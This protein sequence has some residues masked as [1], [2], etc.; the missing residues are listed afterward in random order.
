MATLKF[1]QDHEWLSI[2]GDEAV[3]GITEYAQAQL[4]DIVFVELPETGK[5]FAKGDEAAVVESVKAAAE[6]YA[7]LSGEIADTNSSL[8]D[9]PGLVNSEAETGGWFFKLKFSDQ[10]ELDGLMDADGYKAFIADLG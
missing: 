2:A 10:T 4:G 1:T 8:D 6:V 9:D 5:S 7:P 3:V